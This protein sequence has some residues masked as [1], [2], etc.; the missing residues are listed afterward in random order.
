MPPARVA[1]FPPAMIRTLVG[2]GSDSVEFPGG[3]CICPDGAI[4]VVDFNTNVL[5]RVTE[6]QSDRSDQLA[7]SVVVTAGLRNEPGCTDGPLGV[8]RFRNPSGVACQRDGTLLVA[9]Q[10]NHRIASV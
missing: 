9:D 2:P 7:A 10:G 3:L 8:A 1:A 6:Q 5:L 4:A